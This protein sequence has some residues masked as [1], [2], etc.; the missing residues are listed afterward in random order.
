MVWLSLQSVLWRLSI[1]EDGAP[2]ETLDFFFSFADLVVTWLILSLFASAVS[3]AVRKTLRTKSA[4]Q[5]DMKVRRGS[6]QTDIPNT[7]NSI[8]LEVINTR[9]GSASSDNS[10]VLPVLSFSLQLRF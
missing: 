3:K 6:N 10:M 9:S 5:T 8:E 2:Q 4:M 1:R 7:H